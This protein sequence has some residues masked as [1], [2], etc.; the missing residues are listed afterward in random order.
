MVA[1]WMLPQ[2][3]GGHVSADGR[4]AVQVGPRGWVVLSGLRI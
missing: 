4:V 1:E 2:W 3:Y